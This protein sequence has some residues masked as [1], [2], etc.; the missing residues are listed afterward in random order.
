V[1]WKTDTPA[2]DYVGLVATGDGSCVAWSELFREC[3]GAIG[4]G[5]A[6][7]FTI[8]R[9]TAPN[10]Y[11]LVRNFSLSDCI[12]TGINGR[13]DTTAIGDDVQV[14]PVGQFGAIAVYPGENGVLDTQVDPNTDDVLQPGTFEGTAY[15]YVLDVASVFGTGP[16]GD[17]V[18]ILCV[19]GQ[20]NANPVALFESHFVI[21]WAGIIYDPSYGTKFTSTSEHEAASFDGFGWGTS[22]SV[23]ANPSADDCTY[24]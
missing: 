13:C 7:D 23:R 9:V 11:L 3:A 16:R 22:T 20:G 5:T 8:L 1:Y 21:R 15:P 2:Q 18:D 24:Q 17:A 14:T 6:S 4:L 10:E 19:A 12:A